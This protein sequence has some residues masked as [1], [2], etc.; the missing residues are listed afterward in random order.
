MSKTA[1]RLCIAS[2][3]V[4]YSRSETGTL[5]WRSSAKNEKNTANAARSEVTS[6]CSTAFA[7]VEEGE[8]L[9][10]MDVLLVF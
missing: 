7:P 8:A 10:Q 5:A 4:K 3:K 1:M 9:E 6:Q 2:I